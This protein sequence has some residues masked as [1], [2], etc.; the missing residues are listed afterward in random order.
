MALK[1]ILIGIIDR[2]ASRLLCLLANVVRA[3]ESQNLHR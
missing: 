3:K 1:Y 2:F